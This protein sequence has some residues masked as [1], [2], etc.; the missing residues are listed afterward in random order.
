MGLFG[1]KKTKEID[2]TRCTYCH[3]PF[4]TLSGG[5]Y[6]G[7]QAAS[8][9]DTILHMRKGCDACGIPVCFNCAVDAADRRGM[10][11]HCICPGCGANLD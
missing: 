10:K 9:G 7:D 4:Q 11:G 2:Q 8:F 6:F 3:T 5:F 1:K